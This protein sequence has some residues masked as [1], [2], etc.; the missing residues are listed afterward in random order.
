MRDL[1]F[2]TLLPVAIIAL[3][4]L[5]FQMGVVVA[6]NPE[7]TEAPLGIQFLYCC[8][9]FTLGGTSLGYP[10][11]GPEF[12]QTILYASYFIAPVVSAAAFLELFYMLSRPLLSY[13]PFVRRNYY[14]FGYGRVGRAAIN[15]LKQFNLEQS[16]RHSK[17][18]FAE[19]IFSTFFFSSWLHRAQYRYIIIDKNARASTASIHLFG[20]DEFFIKQ[21]VQDHAI[22]KKLNFRKTE[23]VFLLTDDETLNLGLLKALEDQLGMGVSAVD[24]KKGL[25]SHSVARFWRKSNLKYVFVRMNSRDFI[26]H[27]EK[28]SVHEAQAQNLLPRKFFFNTHIAAAGQF[29]DTYVNPEIRE[30][31][32]VFEKWKLQNEIKTWV[33][34]GFGR[35]SSTLCEGLLKREFGKTVQK[36]IIIDPHATE[37]HRIFE[38]EHPDFWRD[39]AETPSGHFAIR[40]PNVSLYNQPM[41]NFSNFEGEL[42]KYN[43][44]SSLVVFGSQ[45]DPV[46]FKT[47]ITFKKVFG[48]RS[49]DLRFIIRCRDNEADER[50]LMTEIIAQSGLPIETI[51]VPTYTWVGAYFEDKLRELSAVSASK[52]MD[53]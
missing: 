14:I 16:K 9:L 6:A 47:A 46:N 34:F 53:K 25:E 48:P 11:D 13:D 31:L 3:S 19:S 38:I 41:E 50:R 15:K 44:G 22:V 32:E 40:K 12:W 26:D 49:K 2:K 33:F 17:T 35:F 4:V 51:V 8:T 21:D 30:Q 10:V 29:F 27:M 1:I 36:I 5:S 23:G 43:L 28:R 39:S 45:L 37:E 7:L 52:M 20:S 42:E 24:A 18:N